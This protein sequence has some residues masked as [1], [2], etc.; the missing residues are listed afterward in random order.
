[1]KCPIESCRAILFELNIDSE[2][3]IRGYNYKCS[4]CKKFFNIVAEDY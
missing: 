4:K 2:D 3:Y 1:M